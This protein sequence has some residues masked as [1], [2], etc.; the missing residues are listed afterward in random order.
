MGDWYD[1]RYIPAIL[2]VVF[3]G[4]ILICEITNLINNKLKKVNKLKDF[5]QEQDNKLSVTIS[6]FNLAQLHE[7]KS[8]KKWVLYDNYICDIGDY[9]TSHPGGANTIQENLYSDMSR[10]M[11]GTQAYS[12][13]IEA[14]D[15]NIRTIQH[16]VDKMCYGVLKDNHNIIVKKGYLPLISDTESHNLKENHSEYISESYV[17]L[18]SKQE[19]AE[20]IFE[21]KFKSQRGLQFAKILPGVYSLGR[22]YS[23]SSV[24]LNKTRYYSISMCLNEVMKKKHLE[25]IEN[26][27]R[28][29]NNLECVNV[30]VPEDKM[31][32]EEFNL[33]IKKYN[34]K[35][36]L[37]GHVDKFNNDMQT[38]L[39]IRGPVGTGLNLFNNILKGTNVIFAAGT[40]IIPFIDLIAFTVTY[41]TYQISQ[42]EFKGKDN[43]ILSKEKSIFKKINEDPIV[44][45]FKICLYATF[46]SPKSALYMDICEALF[47][48]DRKY[49]M[50]IFKLHVKNSNGEKWDKDFVSK[51]L[52]EEKGRIEK[53]YIVGPVSFMENVEKA[54]IE[55]EVAVKEAI[56]KV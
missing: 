9:I 44:P 12:S 52:S 31:Y 36:G 18:I 4:T 6:K 30:E 32:S 20:N 46:S 23:L 29:E 38:D 40:G 27:K 5:F 22:H 19:I 34:F 55:S 42:Q 13:Q 11:T 25:L 50:N 53:V 35:N 7:E 17:H 56:I 39:I 51:N 21:Y 48:L 10:F 33:Y 45:P 16:L 54:V 26:I 43:F 2:C 47:E 28:L 49:N 24:E 15:H 8:K 14:Y 1:I 37:S 41:M 3:L